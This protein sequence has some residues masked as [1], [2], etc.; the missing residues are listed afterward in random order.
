[1]KL[2]LIVLTPGKTQGKAIPV[3][4]AQFLIGR[5]PHCHLRPASP[6]ISNRHCAL[7]VRGGKVF[8]RD[9]ES[10][11]GTFLNKERVR[12]EKELCPGDHLRL[13]P[14]EFRVQIDTTQMSVDRPTPL[15]DERRQA[16]PE[17]DEAAA[18]LLLSLQDNG[19]PPG[20]KG[21]DSEGVP[22]GSTVMEIPVSAHGGPPQTEDGKKED[23]AKKKK[24]AEK[25]KTGDTAVVANELLQKYLRRPRK[26]T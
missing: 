14:L 16:E 17:A 2:S 15:P 11:N 8:V 1:M 12:G 5:D 20:T 25:A 10:T 22:T 21:L 9:F 26:A 13:G 7:L 6:L 18:A 19:P 4:L 23:E 3:S 24:E